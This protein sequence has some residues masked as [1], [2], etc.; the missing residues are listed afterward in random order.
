MNQYNKKVVQG[1]EQFSDLELA[2]SRAALLKNK[3]IENIGEFLEE[4]ETNFTQRGGKVIWAQDAEEAL[5]EVMLIMN[6]V[7]AKSIVKGKSMVTEEIKLN[8]ELEKN[9][10]ESIETDLGEYIVQLRGEP[11]YHIV[12]PAMHLSK[13]DIA[14]TFNEKMGTPIDATPE[15]ITNF[16]RNELRA[17]YT[18]ADVGITGGNFIVS[19]IGAIATTENEGNG[20][21]STAFPKVQIA[22]VGIEKVIPSLDDLDLLWPLLSA[23]GTGQKVTVYNNLF[24]GPKQDDEADGPEEMYVI[25]L[26][27]NRTTLLA[28]P[29]QRQALSCIR[30]GACLNACPV[31]QTVG[32]HTYGTVYSG[33]IGAVIT[34]HLAGMSKFKHLSFASSLC[35]KCTEVCPVKIDIHKHLLT[36]RSDSVKDISSSKAEKIVWFFWKTAMLKRSKMD[37]GGPKLKNYILNKFF[38]KQW[39]DRRDLPVVADKSFNQRWKEINHIK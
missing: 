2:K 4:F 25:L 12:T 23:Y 1:K 13:E 15:Y 27:N 35:G 37:K 24:M 6:R 9:D 8:E 34:P 26:D 39:G 21:M 36:N 20:L 31:Y 11:P 16:V 7:G 18:T 30:C 5:K 14:E 38:K 33:P 29:K 22:I 32:G 3:A 10:I 19:D 28:K 17:K